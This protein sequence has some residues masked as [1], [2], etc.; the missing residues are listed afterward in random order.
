LRG[1]R[2]VP[3][4]LAEAHVIGTHEDI[5][6]DNLLVPLEDGIGW[7]AGRVNGQECITVNGDR[8][9]FAALATCTPLMPFGLGRIVR[10]WAG[11]RWWLD[12]WLALFTFQAVDFVPQALDLGLGIPQGGG[13]FLDDVQQAH[14]QRAHP[15]VRDTAQIEVVQH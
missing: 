2:S 5:L 1:G 6:N 11:W 4:F 13:L 15:F 12:G 9:T 8:G 14:D 3:D 10:W 7:Q